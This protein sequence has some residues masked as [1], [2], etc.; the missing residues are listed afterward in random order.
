MSSKPEGTPC[1]C[2]CSQSAGLSAPASGEA[3]TKLVQARVTQDAKSRFNLRIVP[4][5]SLDL[6]RQ[7]PAQ[8]QPRGHARGWGT[9]QFRVDAELLTALASGDKA[10]VAWLAKDG[11]HAD[12]F[13]ANPV[14]AMAEAG[15]ALT[16][17]QQK[18]LARSSEE[19][20]AARTVQ[21]GKGGVTVAT[22]VFPKG[23]VGSIGA[24]HPEAQA[25]D[26]GCGPKRKG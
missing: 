4:A 25:D 7:V 20:A 10:M 18:T 3:I 5:R 15:V 26:F 1:G 8:C 2:N 9:G 13:L 22:Q 11:G 17:A 12:R 24:R 23:R 14:A 21:A 16:R 6:L 19:V